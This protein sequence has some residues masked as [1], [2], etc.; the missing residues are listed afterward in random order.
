MHW[1]LIIKLLGALNFVLGLTMLAPL[2]IAYFDGGRDLRAFA[3]SLVITLI[4]SGL[5]YLF[6]RKTNEELGHR[7]AFLMVTLAWASACFFGALPFW[8][9]GLFGG[10][11]NAYFESASGFTT[12]GST[13]LTDIASMP[14]ATLF[15]RS[16]I[17]WYGGMGIIVLSIA[18]LPVLGVGGMQLFKAEV[19]GPTTDKLQPRV[20]DTAMLLWKVYLLITAVE[21]ILLM[22]GGMGS[23]DA[24][25]HSFTTL[26]T[27]GFSTRPDSFMS[28]DSVFIESTVTFFMFL[29]GINFS[30]HYLAL[31]GKWKSYFRDGELKVY[32]SIILIAILGL[33]A[34]LMISKA[35]D[36]AGDALR[37]AAFQIVSIVTTTGFNSADFEGWA[38]VAPAA[39]LL[40]FLL[41]FPG[42]MAGST[43][44]GI[45]VA[46]IRLLFK[47]GYRELFHLI[48]PRAIRH[49]KVAGKTVPE[50]VLAAVVGFIVIYLGVFV[51]GS[52]LVAFFGHDF[53]TSFSSVAACIGNIGPGLGSVG[54]T[55]NFNH[56]E[57]VIK[58]L[59]VFCMLLGR[60]EIYTVFLLLVPEF[61]KK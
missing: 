18:I 42:G 9:S 21:A 11:T 25:C 13:I 15:W 19:P 26:A 8:L 51:G 17:Q 48:H 6:T 5:A 38:K 27:G 61:W 49:V 28:A 24:I 41:M 4:V 46:R 16:I 56:L 10:F 32:A 23:F 30:L 36:S 12:T 50:Q 35:Y 1:K 29:A 45:K 2:C 59:L 34:L 22:I 53:V 57:P 37:Y 47:H 55:D 14:R 40:L 44:G 20:R 7:E 43:G 60:L 52:L 31:T 33:A 58:W 54:P 39:P 3:V